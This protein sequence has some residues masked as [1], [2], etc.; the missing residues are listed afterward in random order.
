MSWSSAVRAV[1]TALAKRRIRAGWCGAPPPASPIGQ[2]QLVGVN[3]SSARIPCARSLAWVRL[4]AGRGSSSSCCPRQ[5]DDERRHGD[6]DL[7]ATRS[8]DLTRGLPRRGPGSWTPTSTAWG[9]SG[10]SS[11]VPPGWKAPRWTVGDRLVAFTALLPPE[12]LPAR[13]SSGPRRPGTALLG[14]PGAVVLQRARPGDR[15]VCSLPAPASWDGTGSP[16]PRAG[17]RR[18]GGRRRAPPLPTRARPLRW[19]PR[20]T[21]CW[22]PSAFCRCRIRICPTLDHPELVW[23]QVGPCRRLA[24]PVPWLRRSLGLKV[25]RGTADAPA[26]RGGPE[27]PRRPGARGRRQDHRS[28]RPARQELVTGSQVVAAGPRTGRRPSRSRLIGDRRRPAGRHLVAGAGRRAEAAPCLPVVVARGATAGR[29]WESDRWTRA[30]SAPGLPAAE[31]RWEAAEEARRAAVRA[32]GRADRRS[33][34]AD[35]WAGAAH[36]DPGARAQAL[37]RAA[38]G[39]RRRRADDVDA[40]ATCGQA[41]CWSTDRWS[42]SS[43]G[44]MPRPTPARLDLLLLHAMRAVAGTDRAVSA[45]LMD[46]AATPARSPGRGCRGPPGPTTTSSTAGPSRSLPS[47]SPALT[48]LHDRQGR[49]GATSPPSPVALASE[50]R[51]RRASRQPAPTSGRPAPPAA[52][53]WLATNGVNGQGVAGRRCSSRSQR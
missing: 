9:Q 5:R 34:W 35:Q 4:W 43:T 27:T 45:A 2:P 47:C 7:T 6:G 36:V 33:G 19:S 51:R 22:V 21:A 37:G 50:P 29:P 32:G 16:R 39:A 14:L 20:T 31:R 49:P 15:S 44:T 18:P 48:V 53:L 30:A 12:P 38:G 46:L 24:G 41:T 26:A 17:I 52:R 11:G 3:R 10:P 40:T 25:G 28:D 23:R 13:S 8:R 1:T 42:R